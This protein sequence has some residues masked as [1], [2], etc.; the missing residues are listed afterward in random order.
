LRVSEGKIPLLAPHLTTDDIDI[1]SQQ[2]FDYG[3]DGSFID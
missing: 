1:L 2:L 3:A